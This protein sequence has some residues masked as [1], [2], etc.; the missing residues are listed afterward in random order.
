MAESRPEAQS[1]GLDAV[2]GATAPECEEPRRLANR[3]NT[4]SDRV[5]AQG[6]RR[7]EARVCWSTR[8]PIAGKEGLGAVAGM[9]GKRGQKSAGLRCAHGHS[10]KGC[11]LHA[12]VPLPTCA[13]RSSA[14]QSES[15]RD[16]ARPPAA[17]NQLT[18]TRPNIRFLF[19]FLVRS[20]GAGSWAD[21]RLPSPCGD[22]G[23]SL[24]SAGSAWLSS[25]GCRLSV[26]RWLLCLRHRLRILPDRRGGRTAD[27]GPA[28]GAC[29]F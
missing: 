13:P 16:C 25:S 12:H 2:S 14:P 11:A 18:A 15:V 4:H 17:E 8:G 29:S 10:S 9:T 21:G 7:A 22:S 26:P 6:A 3:S 24:C 28:R 27:R 1:T 20:S 5:R 19:L 23:S